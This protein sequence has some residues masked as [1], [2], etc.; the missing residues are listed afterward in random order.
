MHTTY[1]E[2]TP[3]A[4]KLLHL[5]LGTSRPVEAQTGVLQPCSRIGVISFSRKHRRR[6]PG[7][8]AVLES[9]LATKA[10]GVAQALV[11]SLVRVSPFA[12]KIMRVGSEQGKVSGARGIVG[13]GMGNCS[14]TISMYPYSLYHCLRK[15]ATFLDFGILSLA[16]IVMMYARSH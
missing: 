9:V 8:A 15:Q 11:R 2:F 16:P 10:P 7:P 3:Y 13:E 4:V 6:L 5:F 12:S 14:E 1:L